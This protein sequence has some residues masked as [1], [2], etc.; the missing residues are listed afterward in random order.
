M[1]VIALVREPFTSPI[2]IYL[3]AHANWV[4]FL[5]HYFVSSFLVD[6]AFG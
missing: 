4:Y 5:A 1:G 3:E 6:D 2:F